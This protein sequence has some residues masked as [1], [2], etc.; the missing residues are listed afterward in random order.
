[1]KKFAVMLCAIA[2]AI[3]SV[4]SADQ[5]HDGDRGRYGQYGRDD[6]RHDEGYHGGRHPYYRQA[7]QYS[8]GDQG[9]GH[10]GYDHRYDRRRH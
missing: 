1:M 9:H 2:A 7:P 4:A 8:Q 10:R 6:R 5:R 3:P